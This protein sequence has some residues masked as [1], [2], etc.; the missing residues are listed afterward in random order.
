MLEITE[1]DIYLCFYDIWAPTYF[2]TKNYM[3]KFVII[4][5]F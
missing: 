2:V 5:L 1:I 4:I 3:F